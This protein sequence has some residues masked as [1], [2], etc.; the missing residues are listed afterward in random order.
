V[1]PGTF[2]GNPSQRVR[3][4]LWKKVTKRTPSGYAA[5]IWSAPT[6][7]GFSYRQYGESKRQL[8]D[9]EGVALVRLIT[10]KAK[11]GKKPEQTNPENP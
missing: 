6:P 9:Y 3:D 2:L 1:R 4:E 8:L 11:R 5:Q 7:Q 10:K